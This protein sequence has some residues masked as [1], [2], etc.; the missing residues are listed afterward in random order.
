M[1]DLTMAEAKEILRAVEQQTPHPEKLEI[2][3]AA[4]K[5]G[6]AAAQAEMKREG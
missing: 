2:I 6:Y 1:K 3:A 4:Y 5:R